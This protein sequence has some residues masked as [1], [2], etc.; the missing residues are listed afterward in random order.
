M[1]QDFFLSGYICMMQLAVFGIT[2]WHHTII[3]SITATINIQCWKLSKPVFRRL[4][5]SDYR[6][7]NWYMLLGACTSAIADAP[8]L[9]SF[10]SCHVQIMTRVTADS[11]FSCFFSFVLLNAVIVRTHSLSASYTL[12]DPLQSLQLKQQRKVN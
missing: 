7:H 11:R 5:Q 9:N 12:F 6:P 1:L 4:L 2:P 3:K 10:R 8:D